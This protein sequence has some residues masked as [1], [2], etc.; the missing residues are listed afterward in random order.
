MN[1]QSVFLSYNSLSEIEQILALRLHTIG[2]VNGMNMYLPDRRIKDFQSDTET[3]LRISLADWFV[4]FSV[5]SK[6]EKRVLDEINYFIKM[7][8]NPK[9][10]ILVYNPVL[11]KRIHGE[12]SRDFIDIPFDPKRQ[13]QQEINNKI[14]SEINKTSNLQNELKGENSDSSLNQIL[15]LL[16]IG[17]GLMALNSLSGNEKKAT[18]R[19]K[20]Y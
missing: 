15:A 19:K 1:S 5:G 18:G 14:I 3:M 9:R 11:G 12:V 10:V 7:K 2:S 13:S 6:I 16:G 20:K 4:L 8:K 17:I